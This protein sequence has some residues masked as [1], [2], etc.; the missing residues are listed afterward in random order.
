[1][2]AAFV[3]FFLSTGYLRLPEALPASLMESMNSV[4]DDHFEHEVPPFRMNMARRVSRLDMLLDRSTKFI[5]ALRS[6]LVL[7]GLTSLLGPNVEVS[8]YRHN[9]ATLNRAGDIPF[10]LHRDIQQW[11]RQLVSV[12][13]YLEDSTI[14]NGCTHIIPGSH[15][16]PSLLSKLAF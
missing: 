1:M 14:H 15:H 4:V 6:P 5:S 2:E 13:M 10:R 16:I 8:K 7:D 11:S 3:R 12:F 9:H